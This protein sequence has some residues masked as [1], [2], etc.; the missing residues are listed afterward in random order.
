MAGPPLTQ[1]LSAPL[2]SSLFTDLIQFSGRHFFDPLVRDIEGKTVALCFSKLECDACRQLEENLAVVREKWQRNFEVLLISGEESE[3][4]LSQHAMRTKFPCY[5][6]CD[7][8]A[9]VLRTHFGAAMLPKLVV[10]APDGTVLSEDEGQVCSDGNDE[11]DI[12]VESSAVITAPNG[13]VDD[14]VAELLELLGVQSRPQAPEQ[15]KRVIGLVFGELWDVETRTVLDRLDYLSKHLRHRSDMEANEKKAASENSTTSFSSTGRATTTTAGLLSPGRSRSRISRKDMDKGGS[16]S[17]SAA[18]SALKS[19]LKSSKSLPVS[20][21]AQDSNTPAEDKKW[22]LPEVIFVHRENLEKYK[23][24]VGKDISYGTI[25]LTDDQRRELIVKFG[26]G[27]EATLCLISPEQGWAVRDGASWLVQDPVGLLYPWRAQT[28]CSDGWGLTKD[29]SPD[30]VEELTEEALSSALLRGPVCVALLQEIDYEKRGSLLAT[31]RATATEY[32]HRAARTSGDTD[33]SFGKYREKY[34]RAMQISMNVPWR[35][36]SGLDALNAAQQA[37]H[38]GESCWHDQKKTTGARIQC[39]DDD[40]EEEKKDRRDLHLSFHYTIADNNVS[41]WLSKYCCFDVQKLKSRR[42][43]MLQRARQEERFAKAKEDMYRKIE[44]DL[45]QHDDEAF[46]MMGN[47]FGIANVDGNATA[48]TE[49]DYSMLERPH[50]PMTL[51]TMSKLAQGSGPDEFGQNGCGVALILDMAKGCYYVCGNLAEPGALLRFLESWAQDKLIP[52]QMGIHDSDDDEL[53]DETQKQSRKQNACRLYGKP[54]Y[55]PSPLSIVPC[56]VLW[57]PS[58][59]HA[60]CSHDLLAIYRAL[61]RYAY[62]KCPR[63]HNGICPSVEKMCI[64]GLQELQVDESGEAAAAQARSQAETTSWRHYEPPG[65]CNLLNI[66]ACISQIMKRTF[67]DKDKDGS[68]GRRTVAKST[69]SVAHAQ[70]LAMG[71]GSSVSAA[72]LVGMKQTGSSKRAWNLTKQRMEQMNTGIYDEGLQ[73]L[74]SAGIQEPHLVRTGMEAKPTGEAF[75]SLRYGNTR[76]EILGMMLEELTYH[77]VVQR[78]P[79]PLFVLIAGDLPDSSVDIYWPAALREAWVQVI[80]DVPDKSRFRRSLPNL[81][82]ISWDAWLGNYFCDELD[83]N[84]AQGI[85]VPWA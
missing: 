34:H 75:L 62:E 71:G 63:P 20:P 29:G 10:L 22:A 2:H 54:F 27:H 13:M 35:S 61:L 52:C 72:A 55:V 79:P 38:S 58:H 30:V 81:S 25:Q 85:A 24:T 36:Q 28:A 59:Q 77:V 19:G 41:T 83:V 66:E 60:T 32:L 18:P 76:Q 84:V 48:A 46:G 44:D 17:P 73:Q 7:Y 49:P 26:I 47:M 51:Q 15:P 74:R 45:M 53:D 50:L 39:P 69:L 6:W 68:P 65:D 14:A 3:D 80:G 9:A 40:S 67:G 70:S 33:L 31:L 64:F 57:M 16:S 82:V 12:L 23:H 11:L 1:K 4:R 42:R 56:I 5:R 78:P 37:I 8:R 43:I 21:A